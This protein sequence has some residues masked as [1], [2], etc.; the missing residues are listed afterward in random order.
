MDKVV[1]IIGDIMLDRYLYGDVSRIS[2]EAP[3]PIFNKP[4]IYHDYLGGAGNV[5]SQLSR[6][7]YKVVLCGLIANDDAGKT[8]KRLVASFNIDDHFLFESGDVTTIKERYIAKSHQQLLRVDTEI[9]ST[10]PK[11]AEQA[12]LEFIILNAHYI[13][14]IILPDYNKGV[15]TENFCSNIIRNANIYNIETIV[16]IKENNVS[17]YAGATTIKGNINEFAQYVNINDEHI[18]NSNLF[19]LKKLFGAQNIVVTCGKDGIKAID[20]SNQIYQENAISTTVFDVTGAGDI[21]T[22][23][24]YALKQKS[25]AFRDVVRYA[26]KAGGIGV[27]KHGTSFADWDVVFSQDTKCCNANQLP[28]RLIGKRIVFT[29]GCFDILHCGHIELLEYAKSL[30]D[31][32]V[33]GINGDS[34]VKRLKGAS[35]PINTLSLRTKVLSALSCVDYIVSFENDTPID[36]I[37][38]IKPDIIVK[39]G[40]YTENTVVGADFVKSYGGEVKIFPISHS[41][42]TTKLIKESAL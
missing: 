9:Y 17:K 22:T 32:L 15:L 6:L 1:L 37:R 24:L 8:I 42:S 13:D 36:L 10:L 28:A 18:S 16:D 30:G 31:I 25:F 26:N 34:S 29:N 39:G 3:C 2:P 4:K 27:S 33:V 11:C 14:T 38:Q 20:E 40:D 35:R 41:I 19:T 23:Y 12:V 21:V 5:A 7:G